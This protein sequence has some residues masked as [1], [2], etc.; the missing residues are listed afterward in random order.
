VIIMIGE[1]EKETGVGCNA[2]DV[3]LSWCSGCKTH[4]VIGLCKKKGVEFLTPQKG[5]KCSEYD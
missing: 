1:N 4:H 2:F 3:Q 5:I